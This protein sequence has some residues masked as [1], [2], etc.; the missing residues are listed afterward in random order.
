MLDDRWGDMLNVPLDHACP[1]CGCSLAQSRPRLRPRLTRGTRRIPALRLRRVCRCCGRALKI[2]LHPAERRM[3]KVS[4]VMMIVGVLLLLIHAWTWFF[5]AM[6]LAL[7]AELAFWHWSCA[8][9]AGWKRFAVA[10]DA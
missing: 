5:P 10:D 2:N 7:A 4:K 3:N 1:A 6:F 8:H 9:L